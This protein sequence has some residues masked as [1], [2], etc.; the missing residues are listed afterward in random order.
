MI[1]IRSVTI[2]SRDSYITKR[3]LKTEQLRLE[4]A[5]DRI[6]DKRERKKEGALER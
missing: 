3:M 4:L 1:H 6:P 2:H 5:I